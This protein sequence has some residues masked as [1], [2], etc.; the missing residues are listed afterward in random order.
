MKKK[1]SGISMNVMVLMASLLPMLV[2]IIV[3]VVFSISKLDS[4]LDESIYERL[5]VSATDVQ[6]WYEYDIANND[7]SLD[8]SNPE[9]TA[10]IDS[11]LPYDIELTLFQGDTRAMTSIKDASNATGRNIGTQAAADIYATVK[12]GNDYQADGVTIAG[13]QYYVYYKPIYDASGAF[14]GMAFSG[15]P[16]EEVDAMKNQVAVIMIVIG[17]VLAVVFAVIAYFVAKMIST[18]LLKAAHRVASIA[19]GDLNVDTNITATVRETKELVEAT[20]TL[21][22][23]LTSIIGKTKNISTDLVSGAANV[24]ALSE[25]STDGA[26]QIS[27]AIDDLAQGA[28]S[29]AENVQDINAQ[30]IE[31]GYAID[32]IAENADVLIESSNNIK[33]ANT[34]A[35]AYIDKVSDSSVQSVEAVQNISQQISETNAAVNNIKEAVNMIASI[36]SQTN[37]L[38]LNASIEAARAGEAGK[39]FAVVAT[40]IKSLSEQ[41]NGSTEQIKAIVDEI[42]DKSSKSVQ[43][44]AEVAEIITKEQEY[45]EDTQSKFAL[46]NTE[47][48]E[49]LSQ[50]ESITGQI[51]TLNEA[52]D[53]ITSSVSDL[54][55]ISEENAA[56]NQ[57]VAA[58]VSGIVSAIGDIADNSKQTNTFA[59]DL[60]D[61]VAYF[62]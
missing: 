28:T 9:D 32:S 29:M 52:K 11:L 44:S 50:I 3:L 53:R 26:N 27:A 25:T 10:F 46:L 58:S 13:S 8:P 22:Q 5:A 45:I 34:E 39:G 31:M 18:P 60:T 62:K 24:A 2:A 49:S 36:A 30:V 21:Q 47:I 51:G 54:S 35:S 61:T 48:G 41:T 17:V 56:S 14:W 15:E 12:A 19:S 42:V 40:E 1:Q 55:A 57:E 4:E 7:L 16:Q 20:Q 43:L 38:A 33:A 23:E 37:L 59:T 6:V